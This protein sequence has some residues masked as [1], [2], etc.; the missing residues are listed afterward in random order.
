MEK[1]FFWR[2]SNKQLVFKAPGDKTLYENLIRLY[3]SQIH[4]AADF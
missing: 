1:S 4:P 2:S 3:I